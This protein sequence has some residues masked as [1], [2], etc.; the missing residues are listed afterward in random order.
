[1]VFQSYA[2]WPHMTI[3]DNVAFGLEVRKIPRPERQQRVLE[4]L[5]I[6]HMDTYA[7]RKPNQLSGG[8]QQRV[9]LARALVIKPSVLLLDEP[10][11]NLDAKLRTELRSE[12]RRVCKETGI[13]TVYVTH[14]QKEALS[15]A[16][17]VAIM[18]AGQVEQI[19]T[20]EDLY[21]HPTSRFT[22]EFLGETNIIEATITRTEGATIHLETAAGPLIAAAPSGSDIRHPTSDLAPKVLLSIRPESITPT[23]AKGPNTLPAQPQDTTYLGDLAQHTALLPGNIQIK[24]ATLNPAAIRPTFTQVH[25]APEDITLLQCNVCVILGYKT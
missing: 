14:D 7:D 1:M 16:D 23:T 10:L 20:P 17:R 18:R 9:A 19:G 15:M 11:S 13:T 8:Q 21:R 22:A 2:L 12:I 5:R 25:I 24:L 6:V 4:A 3:A